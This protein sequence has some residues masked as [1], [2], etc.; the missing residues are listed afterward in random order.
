MHKQRV[1]A[2]ITARGGSKRVPQKNLRK[3]GNK[4]LLE[5]T[6]EVSTGSDIVDRTVLSTDCPKIAEAALYC[7]CDV[8]FSRPPEL[9]TDGAMSEDVLVHALNNLPFFD[10]VLLLQPS[11]PFRTSQDIDLAFALAKELNRNSC[12]G[13]TPFQSNTDLDQK[14]LFNGDVFSSNSRK[15]GFFERKCGG[16]FILNG[17]IYLIKTSHFLQTK[18]LIDADTIGFQMSAKKSLDI[19]TFEDLHL[20]AKFME[21]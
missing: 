12:V 16:V 4:S 11:S 14:Y 18:K 5:R 15:H 1:L 2:V 19:D 3:L 17:A 6:V 7:G 8:P 13:V 21:I 20:A 10:W 9:A